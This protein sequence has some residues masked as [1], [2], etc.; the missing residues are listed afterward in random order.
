MLP[1]EIITF[2]N[3]TVEEQISLTIS[4]LNTK[5]DEILRKIEVLS[6]E[7]EILKEGGNL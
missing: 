2:I 4:K 7:I 5:L 1:Q 6:T 3:K